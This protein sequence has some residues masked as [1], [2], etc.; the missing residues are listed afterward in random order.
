MSETD[1]FIKSCLDKVTSGNP[2][3]KQKILICR[4]LGL[5]VPPPPKHPHVLLTIQFDENKLEMRE[6]K[7]I[8]VLL[9]LISN[10]SWMKNNN[11]L[12]KFEYF[13]KDYP[14]VGVV[15]DNLRGG[16]NLHVHILISK[17]NST[18]I[19]Q[20][21]IRDCSSKYKHC[22][23]AVNYQSSNSLAH[24]NNRLNYIKGDK[25][26]AEK[27]IFQTADAYWR[28]KHNIPEYIEHA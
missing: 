3:D 15:G 20:K 2:D 16:G 10:F 1:A 18:L 21:V 23:K 8:P 5:R 24:Y 22:F 12:A 25:A 7:E 26:S 28:K 14:P 11:Y 27:C 17:T 9:S 19:K 6:K 4:K 13:S